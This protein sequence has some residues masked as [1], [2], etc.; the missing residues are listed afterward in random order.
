MDGKEDSR[1]ERA[2]GK[3]QRRGLAAI[4][5]DDVRQRGSACE[6]ILVWRTFCVDFAPRRVMHF[7]GGTAIIITAFLFLFFTQ[8]DT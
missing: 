7:G 3:E 6:V 4:G 8:S 2:F 1:Q 5:T